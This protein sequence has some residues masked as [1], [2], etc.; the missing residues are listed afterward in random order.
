MAKYH[1]I[2]AAAAAA[3]LV[4]AARADDSPLFVPQWL[5]AQY[6]LIDQHQSALHSP[7]AGA[8]SLKPDGDTARSNSFG[9]YFGV[10]LPARLQ[11][12][13]DV[14]MFKGGAVSQATGLGGFVNGD[15]VHAGS[16]LSHRAYVARRFL[17]WTLPLASADAPLTRAQDQLPDTESARQI[18]VKLG[19]LAVSDDFDRNR[20]VDGARAQFLNWSLVNNT[21]W[22][23]AADTRGYTS[24]LMLG[25]INPHWSLRYGVYEMPTLA[26]GPTL[27]NSLRR[28]RGE[29]M[30][31]TLQASP[32]GG[33]LRL[34]AYRNKASMGSYRD[35][36]AYA[37]AHG[38]VPDIV[39]NDQPGRHKS[40]FTINGELPLADN[41]DTGLFARF[42]WNGGHTESFAYTEVD[43]VASAGVQ[44]SGT[45]WH[46][47]ADHIGLGL[48]FDG[49]SA[50]HRDY[51]AMGGA[52]FVLGDGALRYGTERIAEFYYS[53][54]L[55]RHL[56]I[57][58][59]LQWIVNPGYNRDR[60]PVGFTGLRAHLE[61]F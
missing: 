50:E 11:F 58:P 44:W 56:T 19:E 21:A 32:D 57:S 61:W 1:L 31:L 52:G 45:H 7:Y 6:T 48:A 30:E 46:R 17:R 5:G 16:S 33:V 37:S 60:G 15:V 25:W 22:D 34:L 14:E 9:A 8:L 54:A 49:L 2:F 10:A 43:R 53:L 26:N 42:G 35:A 27:V 4:S 3:L 55:G 18:E 29:Q 59:D 20:Y 40:G 24:G 41:G 47:P 12:Y 36:I 23:Y 38:I 51:L 13:I 39:A 28:A